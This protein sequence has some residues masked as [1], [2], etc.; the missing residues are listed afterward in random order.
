M[1]PEFTY[2]DYIALGF[3][4]F[5]F[6]CLFRKKNTRKDRF[7]LGFTISREV[8]YLRYTLWRNLDSKYAYCKPL[9]RIVRIIL[10]FCVGISISYLFKWVKEKWNFV[11]Y[12]P[13][14]LL[15]VATCVLY[16]P[17]PIIPYKLEHDENIE[18]YLRIRQEY[19]PKTWMSV[20]N[21]GLLCF[22]RNGISYASW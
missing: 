15:A 16:K 10:P 21:R 14:L 19:L 17:T 22:T 3:C 7:I 11:I 18:Q 12:I 2:I 9:K 4:G 20:T 13:L 6:L 5:L 8:V 1:Y